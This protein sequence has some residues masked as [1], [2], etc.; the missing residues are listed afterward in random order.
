MVSVVA[1]NFSASKLPLNKVTVY[2]DRAEVCR[3]IQC[4][5]NEGITNILVEKLP[6]SLDSN[7]IRVEGY[8]NDASIVEVKFEEKPATIVSNMFI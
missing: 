1:Q 7:S 2:N 5:V 8:G 3:V 4:Q 6:D